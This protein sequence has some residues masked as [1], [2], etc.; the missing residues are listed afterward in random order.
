[1]PGFLLVAQTTPLGAL[2]LD[3]VRHALTNGLA[4]LPTGDIHAITAA[5]NLFAAAID[6]RMFH[7]ATQSDE[8]PPSALPATLASF[9]RCPLPCHLTG[10]PCHCRRSS[11]AC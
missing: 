1:L 2:G 3:P 6:A 4:M 9:G 11:S 5:N 10:K 8:V 7:E